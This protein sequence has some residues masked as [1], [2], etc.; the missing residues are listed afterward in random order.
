MFPYGFLKWKQKKTPRIKRKKSVQWRFLE[1]DIKLKHYAVI[2]KI[3]VFL[4]NSLAYFLFLDIY[5]CPNF[6]FHGVFCF[7]F[8]KAET[9]YFTFFHDF[10]HFFMYFY[11]K[12]ANGSLEKS[13]GI[14]KNNAQATLSAVFTPITITAVWLIVYYYM[15]SLA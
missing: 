4:E 3:S 15:I 14:P 8:S 1:H 11:K 10:C 5:K 6:F 2:L 13:L 7:H 12:M 9:Q